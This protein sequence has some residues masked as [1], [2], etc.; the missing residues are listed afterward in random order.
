MAPPR[1]VV[2]T[3]LDGTL[4]DARYRFDAARPALAALKARGVPVVFCSAKTRAEQETLRRAMALNH[5]FIVENGSAVFIP[6]RYFSRAHGR[7]LHGYDAVVLGVPTA[8][9][10]KEIA[11]LQQ[12]Y[13]LVGYQDLGVD[14]VAR[15]TGLDPESARRARA[16]DFGETLVEADPKALAVLAQKFHVVSGGRFTQVFGKGADKGKAVRLLASFYREQ[17][18]IATVGIGNA[19]NDAPMLAAVD[20]PVLVQNPGGVHAALGVPGL[21]R[22]Q[23]VGPEGWRAAIT[24]FVLA[25]L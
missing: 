13:R 23:G 21:A 5:P 7:P 14:E 22:V 1:V 10:R 25:R 16:R 20:T 8:E 17:G 24:R 18:P 2:F 19:E 12:R 4:L 9:I 11:R 3:D 15:V 6:P